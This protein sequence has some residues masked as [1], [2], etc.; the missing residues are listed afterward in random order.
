M[1]DLGNL[2]I[3]YEDSIPELNVGIEKDVP[4]AMFE[5]DV[6]EAMTEEDIKNKLKDITEED[7]KEAI[8]EEDIKNINNAAENENEEEFFENVITVLGKIF[9]KK[10]VRE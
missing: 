7:V 3:N 10:I 6:K 4:K 9:S 2:K 5:E 8:T 1:G